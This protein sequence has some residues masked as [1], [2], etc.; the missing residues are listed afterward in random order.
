MISLENK[1]SFSILEV[2]TL[3]T[4]SFW[5]VTEEMQPVLSVPLHDQ[6]AQNKIKPRSFQ[7]PT[8]PKNH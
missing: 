5:F 4:A 7:H 8:F 2:E 3:Q 1:L 6:K